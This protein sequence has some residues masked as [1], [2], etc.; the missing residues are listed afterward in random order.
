MVF[1]YY[2]IFQM[3]HNQFAI[4]NSLDKSVELFVG[5]DIPH[6]YTKAEVDSLITNVNLVNYYTTHQV[7][8]LISNINLVG[9]YTKNE[10]GTVLYIG[11]HSLTLIADMSFQN[12]HL[13]LDLKRPHY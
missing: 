7:D 2:S 9:Y 10:V 13:P 4:F 12:N 11:D 1:Q 6:F 3:A 8:S 5:L